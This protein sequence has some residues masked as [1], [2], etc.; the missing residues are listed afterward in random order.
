MAPGPPKQ[1]FMAKWGFQPGSFRYP[2]HCSMPA[3]Y[4]LLLGFFE[5]GEN[6]LIWGGVR[7]VSRKGA[8]GKMKLGMGGKEG[9]NNCSKPVQETSEQTRKGL[10]R[11]LEDTLENNRSSWTA[12]GE[13]GEQR[14]VQSF[15]ECLSRGNILTLGIPRRFTAVQ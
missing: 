10:E 6:L 3:C 7:T 12:S 11:Q 5:V 4:Y 1:A 8:T 15:W 2:N 14:S 13:G 9:K